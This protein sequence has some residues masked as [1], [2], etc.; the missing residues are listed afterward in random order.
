VAFRDG[1]VAVVIAER[2]QHSG[3]LL[4]LDASRVFSAWCLDPVMAVV[5][6]LL[7][8]GY[9]A[10]VLRVRA[11]GRRWPAGRV[12]CF[13]AGFCL[14]LVSTMGVVGVYEAT[15]F[16]DRAVQ[17]AL[18]LMVVPFLLACGA[19]LSL[20]ITA[21][22]RFDGPVRRVLATR[23]MRW[24]TFPALVSFLLLVLP[25]LLYCTGWNVASLRSSVADEGSRL[26]LLAAGGFYF[27]NRLR[28][29]PVPH[30]TPHLISAA[31][32]FGEGI[33]DGLVGLLLILG[34]PVAVGYYQGLHR[35]WGPD[36][37]W[38]QVWGGG[39][40]WFIGDLTSLP[41]LAALYRRMRVEDEQQ[42]AS[43]QAVLVPLGAD[44]EAG[45][46]GSAELFRPWWETDPVVGPRYGY[47]PPSEYGPPDGR[48]V[49]DR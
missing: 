27:W 40:F 7:A 31:L 8:V 15:L 39:A 20:L 2:V 41:F 29:D 46:G 42:E 28:L 6:L 10:G 5:V 34:H 11:A 3:D 22:P 4:R 16:W 14:L 45:G 37:Y 21:V 33:A 43:Q 24:A 30:H 12:V 1:G 44:A 19:P 36:L 47:R 17:N 13:A 23:V 49:A 18:L 9:A 26:A 35:G 48:D 32:A 25:F 38:D